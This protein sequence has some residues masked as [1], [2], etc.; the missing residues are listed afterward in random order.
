[1]L[2]KSVRR[3]EGKNEN[4][5]FG[6]GKHLSTGDYVYVHVWSPECRAEYNIR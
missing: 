6:R 1:M 2:N 4:V 5:A 3:I